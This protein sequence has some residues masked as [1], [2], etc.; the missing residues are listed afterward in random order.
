[1]TEESEKVLTEFHRLKT[2]YAELS[3]KFTSIDK[4]YRSQQDNLILAEGQYRFYNK[5]LIIYCINL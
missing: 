1:M 2:E 5:C 3:G 4:Q